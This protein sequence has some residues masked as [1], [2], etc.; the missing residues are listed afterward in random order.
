MR[1]YKSLTIYKRSCD[2]CGAQARN[3]GLEPEQGRIE[4]RPGLS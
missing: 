3:E 2:L 1:G 4:A